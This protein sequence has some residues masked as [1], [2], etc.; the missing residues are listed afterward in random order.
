MFTFS[1]FVSKEAAACSSVNFLL[2]T[3]FFFQWR[4]A[5]SE[6]FSILCETVLKL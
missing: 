4:F 6:C 2:D 3:R 5:P 1:V